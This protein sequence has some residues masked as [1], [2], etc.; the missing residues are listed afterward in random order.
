MEQEQVVF[1]FP[2]FL[3]RNNIS[4]SKAYKDAELGLLTLRKRGRATVVTAA[5]ERAYHEALPVFDPCAPSRYREQAQR[6]RE[7]ANERARHKPTRA[8]KRAPRHRKR[9]A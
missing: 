7:V 5:D 4:K 3:K 6:A 8:T 2:Q 9:R 1:T